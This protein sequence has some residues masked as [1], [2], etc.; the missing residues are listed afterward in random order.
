[1]KRVVIV[2]LILLS[3][4]QPSMA[5][6]SIQDTVYGWTGSS[7]TLHDDINNTGS[8]GIM[9]Y[10]RVIGTNFPAN[11]KPGLGICDNT[12]CFPSSVL[13]GSVQSSLYDPG[14]GLFDVMLDLSSDTTTTGTYWLT[15]RDSSATTVKNATF[16]IKRP[17]TSVTS[18]HTNNDDIT[19]FPN[20]AS[21]MLN[22]SYSS[23]YD[24]K[25]IRICD[26]MGR[27]LIIKTVSGNNAS[28]N[29]RDLLAGNYF[30]TMLNTENKILGI[31]SFSKQ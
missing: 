7:I 28:I 15:V 3:F 26:I 16:V 8:A 12:I 6:F 18:Y 2:A 30:I 24:V 5:Q 27:V 17:P 25:N 11:W 4:V 13:S 1:M 22:I 31:R 9:I 21:D 23:G 20:P 14:L 19:I 29:I 10:W